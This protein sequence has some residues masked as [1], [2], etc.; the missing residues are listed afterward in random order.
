MEEEK[1]FWIGLNMVNGIGSVRFQGLL[2]KF[3]SAQKAWEAAPSELKEA[4]L[5]SKVVKNLLELRASI[6]LQTI[7]DKAG[8]VGAR[9]LT[10]N[11]DAYPR[12]LKNI[13]QPPPILYVRGEILPKDEW[14]V[15]V[16]GTRKF[17]P[18]GQ[19][20]AEEIAEFL[21]RNGVTVIS[22]LARGIDAIAHQSALNAGG[23]SIAVLGS[24]V[25]NIYPPENRGL[26]KELIENGAVVSDYG[27]GTNPEGINFPPRNRIISGLSLAVVVVEA[28]KKSGALITAEFGVNQ[29]REVFGVPGSIF[30]PQSQ[31][32]NRLIKNG[33]NPLL[34]PEDLF[35]AL[36][37]HMLDQKQAAQ[38]VLPTDATEAALYSVLDHDPKHI[39]EIGFKTGLPIEKVSA[40]LALM[41]LKGMVRQVGSMQFVSI[42][43][44]HSD[45]HIDQE[46]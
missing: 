17:T 43:E 36:D 26:A 14:A 24:G 6:D 30:A 34:S 23:R 2:D 21:A 8:K 3:G 20:V 10:W 44:L 1:V 31:G 45:Y 19:Q 32:P 7:G 27:M 41:E 35:D 38:M 29:G 28:G 18:Y 40:T 16:V 22:G 39:D 46:N 42:R 5:S 11:D 15:A 33:A 4:G 37:L 9:I 12:R 25:D 13:D